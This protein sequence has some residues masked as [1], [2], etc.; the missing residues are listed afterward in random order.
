MTSQRESLMPFPYLVSTAK[1]AVIL[2]LPTSPVRAHEIAT[3]KYVMHQFEVDSQGSDFQFSRFPDLREMKE[4]LNS[5]THPIVVQYP[6]IVKPVSG[7]LSEGVARVIIVETY[8]DG[9]EFDANIVL[10]EGEILF[11][12][13]SEFTPSNLP[14]SEREI[15]QNS[16]QRTLL[17]LGFT[18][19]LFPVEG[20]VKDS[21]M[22]FRADESGIFDLR[23]R[24]VTRSDPPSC[25]LIKI[26]A[27]G[28]RTKFPAG[29]RV[30]NIA[31]AK[32][33]SYYFLA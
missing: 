30:P 23:P 15:V 10:C 3:D 22:E 24:L 9:P 21:S 14:S 8:I 2:G 7:Y 16:L 12:E 1:A 5:T 19:E 20:R 29:R 13:T 4:K 17:G 33:S 18:W 11:F 27:R 31:V 28:T 6:A 32:L 26:N 25:F